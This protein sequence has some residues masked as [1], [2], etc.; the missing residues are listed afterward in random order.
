MT[1][2]L[3]GLATFSDEQCKKMHLKAV[4][5]GLYC[6]RHMYM[7]LGRCWNGRH[8]DQPRPE[9]APATTS[10]SSHKERGRRHGTTCLN[11]PGS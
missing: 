9:R 3:R 10:K 4:L 8:A 11:L 1:S 5:G 6:R 7:P 2:A